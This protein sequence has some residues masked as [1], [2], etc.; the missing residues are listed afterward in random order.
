LIF[1]P[2][3]KD[4]GLIN[5]AKSN[6][7]L[8]L[9]RVLKNKEDLSGLFYSLEERFGLNSQITKLESYDISHFSGD[10]AVGACV[11]YGS[12][13]KLKKEYRLYN[14]NKKNAANDIASMQEVIE[15]RFK[16]F[17]PKE[18]DLPSLI[19][20]DGGLDH[21][22]AIRKI[23]NSLNIQSINL[24][25]ISKGARR[26]A[27]MD[28]IQLENGSKFRVKRSSEIDLF[29]QGVRD[30]T[31]RFAISNQKR[32]QEKS[33]LKSSLET[34]PGVGKKKQTVLLRFFG[35]YDQIKRASS[36]DF[37]KVSGISTKTANKIYNFLH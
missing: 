7:D 12:K 2:G 11:V 8:S 17:N 27:E 33:F 15:R 20:L 26:K 5:I 19:I 28:L 37:E 9:R 35:S 10:N 1:K 18:K 34:I 31:H 21:I 22:R 14:I 23:F 32:K 36:T 24:I 29:L 3:K 6:T 16:R 30:E 4:K 25:A 13:G